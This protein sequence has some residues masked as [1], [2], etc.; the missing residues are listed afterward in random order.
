[1]KRMDYCLLYY[2]LTCGAWLYPGVPVI[3]NVVIYLAV[4]M[5]ASDTDA[6][7]VKIGG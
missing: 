6:V 2:G 4:V 5:M 3:Y 1:M 7:F